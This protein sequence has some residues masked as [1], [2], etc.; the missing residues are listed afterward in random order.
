MGSALGLLPAPGFPDYSFLWQAAGPDEALARRQAYLQQLRAMM[1]A[2]NSQYPGRMNAHERTWE[3]WLGRTGELP[4]D[5]ATMTSQGQLPD[6]LRLVIDGKA[7]PIRSVSDWQRARPWIKGQYEKLI[8]GS[9]PPAP[10]NLRAT[11]RSEVM[12]G[13]VTVREVRLEFGPDHKATLNL[14]VQIPPG[15]GP[16]PVFLTNHPRRR[17]WVNTAVR[18][19]YLGCIYYALD[20]YYGHVDDSDAWIDLYPDYDFGAIARW[21]WG[22]MRA[23]D[24]LTTLPFIRKDQIAISGHSRQSKQALLA[25]AFDERIGAVVPSRGNTGDQVPWRF[26]SDMFDAE[27]LEVLTRGTPH[28]F[29][30]RLRFFVGREDKLPVDQNLMMGLIAPRGLMFSHASMEHQ[31]NPIGL[32]TAYRSVRKVYDLYG[33][34]GNLGLYQQPGEHPSSVEDVE[35]YFDFFDHVFKRGRH[36]VPEIWTIGY[37]FDEWKATTGHS[38][39]INEW[40]ARKVGDY[41]DGGLGPAVKSAADWPAAKATIKDRIRWA[42][43]NEPPGLT[44]PSP[45]QSRANGQQSSGWRGDLIRRPVDTWPFM[46]TDRIQ[47]GDDLSGELYSPNAIRVGTPPVIPPF[48]KVP[49]VIWLHP[50]SYAT[51]YS[52]YTL[53]GGLVQAGFAVF[54][55]DQI[56][57]GI[58]SANGIRFYERYED[59]SLLGKM[60]T[61]TQAAITEVTK[62]RWIDEKRVFLSGYSLGGKV[63]LFTAALDDKIAGV[64]VRCAFAPLR[65]S[66]DRDS[67]EGIRHYSHIHGLLP[68]LGFFTGQPSRLPVDY[69]EILAAIA[70][71]PVQVVAPELDRHNPVDRVKQSVEASRRA[72]AL[73]GAE[74]AL[75]INSVLDWNRWAKYIG[76]EEFLIRVAGLPAQPK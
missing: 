12:E 37:T 26:A 52:L 54:C 74:S 62:I 28:W 2:T 30:P 73:L 31:G 72:Y 27:S 29:H 3:Q 75:E 63:A 21:A 42:V 45:D 64:S 33:K 71:R 46:Q 59:W 6:P 44:L 70:P 15:R 7:T 76:Q 10:T 55:F 4:P 61:D 5:F 9:M 47:F 32:E 56:G 49:L 36:T 13:S 8:V 34:S 41:M 1:P 57:F 48:T 53:W 16:F 38:V 20:S 65:L 35:Q 18:R 60:V 14:Q 50:F 69:D 43:G 23:V 11:I 51:G 68:K 40:P 17:P 22:A 25:A 24:Y 19:G 66:G 39:A 67:S 58:R